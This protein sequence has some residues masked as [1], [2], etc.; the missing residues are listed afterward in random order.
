MVSFS[1]MVFCKA[2]IDKTYE[3]TLRLG[4]HVSVSVWNCF[5]LFILG[6]TPCIWIRIH[7]C[8]TK[9]DPVVIQVCISRLYAFEDG[10]KEVACAEVSTCWNCI[11]FYG[12]LWKAVSGS[13]RKIKKPCW[14]HRMDSVMSTYIRTMMVDLA[15][16]CRNTVD[17]IDRCADMDTRVFSIWIWRSTQICI[18]KHG[19]AT[20]RNEWHGMIDMEWQQKCWHY[21]KNTATT[22]SMHAYWISWFISLKFMKEP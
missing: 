11:I 3:W 2:S 10:R 12:V 18:R 21:T 4:L 13:I 14:G 6:M 15:R 1:S 22:F 5:C 8:K 16:Y 19:V 7:I 20:Y 9:T 17:V